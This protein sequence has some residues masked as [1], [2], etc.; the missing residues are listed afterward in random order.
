MYG[1]PSGGPILRVTFLDHASY[2]VRPPWLNEKLLHIRIWWGR[3]LATELALDLETGK[4]LYVE[5]ANFAEFL[6]PCER[7]ESSK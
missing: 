6:G 4:P 7:G 5:D 2:G 1:N 3:I